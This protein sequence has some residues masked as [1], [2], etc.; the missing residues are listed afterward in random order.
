MNHTAQTTSADSGGMFEPRQAASLLNQTTQQ[1]R[2]QFEPNPPWLATIRAVA[3]LGVYGSVWFSVRGQ[4]PYLHPTAAAIPGA[5]A[6]GIANLL[7]TIAVARRA[8]AGVAGRS[9]LRPADIAVMGAV[10]VAVFVVMGVLIGAKVSNRVVYGLY[11]ATAPLIVVGLIWAAVMAVRGG[12]RAC[13]SGL[14]AAAIGAVALAAGPA[15]AW[16]V[17]G[18]GLFVVLLEHA[19]EIAWRQRA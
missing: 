10:W 15:G 17:V 8:S 7:V 11:P 16:L 14:A 13:I 18:L 3:A 4:H 6:F 9:R 5:V 2:R 1:A 19:I 12:R